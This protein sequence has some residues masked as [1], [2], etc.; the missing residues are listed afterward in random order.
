MKLL[1]KNFFDILNSELRPVIINLVDSI[2]NRMPKVNREVEFDSDD[3][4]R[5]VEKVI[6]ANKTLFDALADA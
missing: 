6:K 3:V 4:Y 1:Q 2:C 5:Y